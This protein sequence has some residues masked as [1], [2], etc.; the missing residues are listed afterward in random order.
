[1]TSAS[2]ARVLLFVL[3]AGV[4]VAGGCSGGDEVNLPPQGPG[5]PGTAAG[6]PGGPLSS[7]EI[8]QIM[9]KLNR[10]PTSLTPRLGAE[11]KEEKP[12]WETI[13]A[14][15][16]EYAQLA[17]ELGTHDP[18][19]GTKESWAKLA[20]AFSDSAS[21]LDKAAQAKDKD[22]A[23]AAHSQ[24]SNSCMACHRQH[25]GMGGMGPGMGGMGPGM[26]RMGPPGGRPGGPP[27]GGPA[28]EPPAGTPPPPGGRREPAP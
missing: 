13:Q 12:A 19:M 17:A 16:K 22:G 11:L 4:S 21:E 9:V 7:P 28:A 6:A 25:R 15:T 8:K 10:G 2:R 18:K 1:M 27:G 14:Q 26:G 23:V 20:A 5:G 3:W 24:L